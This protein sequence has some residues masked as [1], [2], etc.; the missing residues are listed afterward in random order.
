M[1]Y[2]PGG[3]AEQQLLGHSPE[4]R[5]SSSHSCLPRHAGFRT[6][7]RRPPSLSGKRTDGRQ[8]LMHYTEGRRDEAK[9]RFSDFLATLLESLF[10]VRIRSY[11]PPHPTTRISFTCLYHTPTQTCSAYEI[12]AVMQS[13]LTPPSETA[14]P[15]SL[16]TCP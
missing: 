10:M 6:I 5:L 14:Y 2:S 8:N 9:T 13:G 12:A 16:S 7:R 11:R 15:S 1:N 4:Y 3:L